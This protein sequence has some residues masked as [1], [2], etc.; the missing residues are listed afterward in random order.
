GRRHLEQVSHRPVDDTSAAEL[1]PDLTA[2][3]AAAHHRVAATDQ[4]VATLALDPAITRQRDPDALLHGVRAAW[5]ADRVADYQQRAL[6]PA[7]TARSTRHEPYPT[8]QID[9]GP[10]IGR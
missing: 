6:G 3:V 5:H 2:E 7:A 1:I 8:P 10:S 9:H 4:R